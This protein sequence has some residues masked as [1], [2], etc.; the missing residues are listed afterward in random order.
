M[1]GDTVTGVTTFML[2]KQIDTGRIIMQRSVEI[3]P[4]DCAGTLHDKLM[5]AGADLVIE[6]VDMIEEGGV[7]TRPQE[8]VDDLLRKE[9]PKFSK[10]HVL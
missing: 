8:E 1:N 7:V 3:E 4:D 6:T 5:V 10:T 9:A 2:D